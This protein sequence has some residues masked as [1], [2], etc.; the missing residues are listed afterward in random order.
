MGKRKGLVGKSKKERL[1]KPPRINLARPA[2]FLSCSKEY[3][4]DAVYDQGS[5]P[6]RESNRSE[7]SY[8]CKPSTQT[9]FFFLW[10]TCR[11]SYHLSTPVVPGVKS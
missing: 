10:Q 8:G 4:F 7:G 3:K 11:L 6:I 9:T 2:T 5:G 1:W